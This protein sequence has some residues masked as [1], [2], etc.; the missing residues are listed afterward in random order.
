MG[1]KV[2][3]FTLPTPALSGS[4]PRPKNGVEVTAISNLVAELL[5]I[6][7]IRPVSV[8]PTT[9]LNPIFAVKNHN[10]S[11]RLILNSKEVNEACVKKIH[12]KM[13]TLQTVLDCIQPGDFLSSLDLKK[14]FHHVALHPDHQHFFGF[15]WQG[16]Q[17][18]FTCL[19]MGLR[20]SPRIFTVLV[21]ALL[22]VL[23]ERGIRVFSYIDD[24]LIAAPSLSLGEGHTQEV[25]TFFESAG[26]I[27]HEAKS[28]LKPSH[29]LHYL[30]F[31]IDSN[32]MV[33]ELPEGK[34]HRLRDDLK[35]LRRHLI[36]HRPI[37][38]RKFATILGFLLSC[39]PAIPYGLGHFRFFE[40]AKQKALRAGTKW[41][42]SFLLPSS[43]EPD[44]QWWESL[45]HPLQ[46]SFARRTVTHTI[47]TDASTTG[48]WGAICRQTKVAGVWHQLN[49]DRIDLLELRAIRF[50]LENL[51][52]SWQN[53]N[54][55]FR[56]DNTVAVSYIN[57]FGGRIPHLDLE[58]RLIW[59]ILEQHRATAV[60]VYIPSRDNPA[61]GLSRLI[62]RSAAANLD[63]EWQLKPELFDALCQRFQFVPDM[64]WFA[65]AINTQLP[66]F[67]ARFFE[68][69]ASEIDA[70]DVHWGSLKGYFFP[71]FCVLHRVI[72]KILQEQVP[73]LVVHPRW[74]SQP[75][76]PILVHHR[77]FYHDLPTAAQSLQLPQ[78]PHLVHRLQK[79]PL[80]CS[81]FFLQ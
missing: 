70:F 21:K 9:V 40:R 1:V 20:E 60:A 68:P 13:E 45:T 74:P 26:F 52:F 35:V 28:A 58:A 6:G 63:A 64:D 73:A 43:I 80:Q 49:E 8:S 25:R 59:Q 69:A 56:V 5:L 48:G 51:P 39:T 71:P 29:R 41:D 76:W 50:G 62:T 46:R 67:A 4:N 79:A 75:W 38:V 10:G 33:V 55:R 16:Q 57:N 7:A 11:Y 31:V 24:S 66:R 65:T 19:P 15:Q 81:A 53:A 22:T 42:Q 27:V 14:G 54:I 32:K 72:I 36:S 77:Q 61:D 18:H 78:F 2:D 44:L 12:F 23:R 47:T 17:F 3:F 30:G 37:V 34:F